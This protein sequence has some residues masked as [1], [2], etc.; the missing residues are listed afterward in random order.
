MVGKGS[1][2]R[3]IC[4]SAAAPASGCSKCYNRLILGAVVHARLGGRALLADREMA[5]SIS[6]DADRAMTIG[7]V[8]ASAGRGLVGGDRLGHGMVV[9]LDDPRRDH[10][11][12]RRHGGKPIRDV[13]L[14]APWCAAFRTSTFS[15][16]RSFATSHVR[17]SSS[18][19]PA[20][21]I[22][23]VPYSMRTTRELLFSSTGQASSTGSGGNTMN[24]TP[25]TASVSAPRDCA[26]M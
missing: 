16:L 8:H 1:G 13:P 22:E 11:R 14:L 26:G 17:S 18:A 10:D 6:V 12:L 4:C 19:S 3:R 21:S 20:N 23:K 25:S 9:A 15:R 5:V 2:S 24:C 7:A